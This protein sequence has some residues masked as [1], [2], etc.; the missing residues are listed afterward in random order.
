MLVDKILWFSNKAEKF[1]NEW[2]AFL[3]VLSHISISRVL[4]LKKRTLEIYSGLTLLKMRI[5]FF[6]SFSLCIVV[7]T[8]LSPFSY[9]QFPPP[10]RLT[11]PAPFLHLALSTCPLSMFRDSPSP[12]CPCYPSSPSPLLLS[13]CSLFQCFWLYYA[14]LFILLIRFHI[15]VRLYGIRLSP[16][17]LFHLA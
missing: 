14:C 17:V 7:Q 15:L 3:W 5:F 16:P 4:N 10:P 12:V 9:H 6:F 13:D 8:Q 1:S 11:H 2:T